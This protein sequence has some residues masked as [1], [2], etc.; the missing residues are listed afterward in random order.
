VD[1]RTP[2]QMINIPPVLQLLTKAQEQL[3]VGKD[4]E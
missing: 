2:L 3:S 4:K 1:G